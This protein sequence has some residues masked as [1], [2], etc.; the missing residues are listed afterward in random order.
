MWRGSVIIIGLLREQ[1]EGEAGARIAEYRRMDVSGSP[2]RLHAASLC[3]I[4]LYMQPLGSLLSD[5]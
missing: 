1:R 5:D 2:T 3:K 4:A